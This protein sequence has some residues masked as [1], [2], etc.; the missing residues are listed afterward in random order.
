MEADRRRLDLRGA[1]SLVLGLVAGLVAAPCGCAR[2]ARRPPGIAG[3][4]PL[5]ARDLAGQAGRARRT[6]S[7]SWRTWRPSRPPPSSREERYALEL[8][9]AR[10]LMELD[11]RSRAVAPQAQEEGRPRGARRRSRRRLARRRVRPSAASSGESGA[12]AALGGLLLFASRGTAT[13]AAGRGLRS[14]A[15]RPRAAARRQ[16]PA[17]PGRSRGRGPD[18][19]GGRDATRTTSS[20]R[21]ALAQALPGTPGH[22]GRVERDEGGARTLAGASAGASRTRPWCALAMGQ[23]DVAQRMLEKVIASS[24]DLLEGYLHLALVHVA[25]GP[26]GRGR[27]RDGQ[28]RASASPRGPRC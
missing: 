22:D 26:R 18:A 15:T 20:A 28:G 2:P 14:P 21:I 1:S 23:G 9:A 5:E 3:R 13:T 19:G 11:D 10:V 16:A 8:E 6:S 25:H 7:G 4:C 17:R 27:G 12:M 24:P